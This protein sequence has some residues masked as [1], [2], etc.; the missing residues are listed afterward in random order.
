MVLIPILVFFFIF[1]I[2]VNVAQGDLVDENDNC[3]VWAETGECDNNPD[4]ML[5]YCAKSCSAYVESKTKYS[6]FYD[7][8]EVDIDGN[9]EVIFF[10]SLLSDSLT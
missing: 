8:K 10:L 9:G 6:S 3:H 5:K 2:S 4:Y 1:S 7:I